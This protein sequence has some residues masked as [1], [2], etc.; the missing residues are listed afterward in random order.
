MQDLSKKEI[1]AFWNKAYEYACRNKHERIAEDFAQEAVINLISKGH[2]P[3]KFVFID[4]IRGLY[5][6]TGKYGSSQSEL[7]SL[8][9]RGVVFKDVRELPISNEGFSRVDSEYEHYDYDWRDYCTARGRAAEI[10]RLVIGEEKSYVEVAEICGISVPRV[11]QIIKSEKK[12][13]A[14]ALFLKE[15]LIL[16]KEHT[17]ESF[18]LVDWIKI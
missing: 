15:R 12:K 16:Y 13:L 2:R 8:E 18:L 5:G 11:C 3:L 4:F 10:C 1:Q 14:N 9:R 17:E 7:K 6:R